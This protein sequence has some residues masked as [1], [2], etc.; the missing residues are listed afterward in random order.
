MTKGGALLSRPRL[1]FLLAFVV[2]VASR[3]ALAQPTTP[4]RPALT[5]RFIGNA[6]FEI[7]D[8]Q[9]TLLTDFPYKSGAFGY[10]TYRMETV[11]PKGDVL[12]LV[13]HAHDDHWSAD[14]FRSTNWMVAGPQSV[15]AGID[16]TRVVPV[17]PRGRFKT[18]IVQSFETRHEPK[19][20][21]SY[22]VLWH[23]QKLYFTGDTE[24][25]DKVLSAGPVDTLFITPWLLRNSMK[26]G[27]KF[28]AKRIVIYHHD[29]SEPLPRCDNCVGPRQGQEIV[30]K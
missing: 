3:A 11:R 25:P 28:Q 29:E 14:L 19:G 17:Y 20:H 8:G 30:L 18:V 21:Y 15:T 26:A 13:T 10:M 12:C 24:V 5:A 22:L 6:A 1:I 7:T 27:L 23:G 16:L 9:T 2:A 4:A